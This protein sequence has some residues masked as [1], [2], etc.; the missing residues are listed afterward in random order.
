[1]ERLS[2]RFGGTTQIER[3]KEPPINI[4]MT[5]PYPFTS[6]VGNISPMTSLSQSAAQMVIQPSIK[7]DPTKKYQIVP[8]NLSVPYTTPN[9]GTAA[10][11][12]PGFAGG[13]N[14]ITMAINPAGAAPTNLEWVD[15]LFPA[16]LY[17]YPDIVFQMNVMAQTAGWTSDAVG[18][19]IFEMTPDYATNQ[20]ILTILTGNLNAATKAAWNNNGLF[21]TF[22]NPSPTLSAA[23]TADS[24]GPVLGWPT[25]GGGA[26]ISV[27][28]ALPIANT[29]FVGPNAANF[30]AYTQYV[31]NSNLVSG[32]YL[33][34]QTN[35]ALISIPLGL[36]PP[37]SVIPVFPNFPQPVMCSQQGDITNCSFWWTDQYGNPLPTFQEPWSI[38]FAIGEIGTSG[39]S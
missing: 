28:G 4:R 21:V 8:Y 19:P 5:V 23:H 29:S 22:L 16:G 35:N 25:T 9:I 31:L 7:L 33:N 14:R 38:S 26:T 27:T 6:T 20:I 3:V 15:Y 11:G 10:T 17:G 2:Q 13:N 37:N 24:V 32:S 34:G 30:V 36:T 1:M 12:V 18:S 39:N